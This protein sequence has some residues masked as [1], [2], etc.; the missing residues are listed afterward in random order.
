LFG[1]ELKNV[2]NDW[3]DYEAIRRRKP[4]EF[5]RRIARGFEG[6]DHEMVPFLGEDVG[7]FVGLDVNGDDFGGEARG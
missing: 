2:L 7:M 4:N 6:R 5:R 3:N 1:S